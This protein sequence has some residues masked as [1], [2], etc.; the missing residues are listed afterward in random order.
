MPKAQPKASHHI[1]GEYVE[2]TAGAPVDSTYPATGEV[3]ARLHAATPAI[4]EKAI[5]SAKHAQKEWAGSLRSPFLP[6]WQSQP[7][8]PDEVRTA[9]SVILMGMNHRPTPIGRHDEEFSP[10]KSR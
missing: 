9:Q 6:R 2:D 5:A 10:R 1:D 3:I 7:F 4:V 8:P